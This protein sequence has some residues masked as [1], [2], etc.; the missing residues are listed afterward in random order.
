MS[1]QEKKEKVVAGPTLEQECRLGIK[2][3]ERIIEEVK[4]EWFTL[5][6]LH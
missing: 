1:D 6:N 4:Q 5:A 2:I 3:G